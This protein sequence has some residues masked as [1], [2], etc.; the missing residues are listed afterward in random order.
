MQAGRCILKSK[1]HPVIL[2]RKIVK[3][4]CVATIDKTNELTLMEPKSL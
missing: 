2:A 1:K 4:G 3:A